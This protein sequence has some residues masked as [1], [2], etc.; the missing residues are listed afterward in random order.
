MKTVTVKKGNL[1]IVCFCIAFII[2]LLGNMWGSHSTRKSIEQR[3][4]SV[5]ENKV[6]EL[7]KHVDE[8]NMAVF[9]ERK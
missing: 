9:N 3:Q 2:L 5:L 4:S 8:L 7:E 6:D 1:A